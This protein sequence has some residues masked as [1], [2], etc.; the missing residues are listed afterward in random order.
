MIFEQK[1]EQRRERERD[2]ISE[3]RDFLPEKTVRIKAI[4]HS[5]YKRNDIFLRGGGD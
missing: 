5:L 1:T 3:R 4:N 2:L